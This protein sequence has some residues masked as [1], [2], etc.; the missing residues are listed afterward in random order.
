MISTELLITLGGNAF[1]TV[2]MVA[3][4]LFVYLHNKDREINFLFFY[5][6]MAIAIF[7]SGFVFAGF[8][9]DPE[10][11]YR[12]WFT[13]I[14][15]VFI[16]TSVV[17]V[18]IRASDQQVRFRWYLHLT[19][20]L[21]FII[22]GVALMFPLLFL[23]EVAPKMYFLTYLEG[24]PW[25]SVMLAY[26]LGMPI[27]P[28]ILLIRYYFISSGSQRRLAEYF[29]LMFAV[30]YGVGPLDFPL[31]FNWQIDPVY[32]MFL[33][34]YLVPVAYGI[35]TDQ[36]LD[37]RLVIKRAFIYALGVAV[38]AGF[39]LSISLL[40]EL[41]I[42]RLPWISYW[43]VPFLAAIVAVVIGRSVWQQLRETDRLKYEFVT[44]ATHKLRTP[45]TR[46]RWIS[47]EVMQRSN[48]PAIQEGVTRISSAADQLIELTNIMLEAAK[49]EDTTLWYRKDPVDLVA[50][51]KGVVD[52]FADTIREKG[53][54][55]DI[56][57]EVPQVIVTGDSKRI[58]SVTEIF[59]EN[60]LLYTPKGG[61]IS[62]N[63]G[64]KG[65]RGFVSVKDTGIG[66]AFQ[67]QEHIFTGFF[68]SDSAKLA[69]TEGFGLGL[70]MAKSII[71]RQGGTI[72]LDSDGA[73]KGSEFWFMLPLNVAR[74][75]A[76][77]DS[78]SKSL[79]S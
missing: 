69:H 48:D 79:I 31:V 77:V 39:L 17:H 44:V 75:E 13:N 23:P 51:T 50:L 41:I 58:I 78:A 21:G 70:S 24:G 27:F 56:H 40:N 29:I 45:L 3:M 5:M 12:V 32:G 53:L 8:I 38:T 11:A 59:V 6:C 60:A 37:I 7:G 67:D 20:I 26:F 25:Y 57:T 47:A 63:I 10:I 16:T 1:F 9:A 42:V 54:T 19:Y 49:T 33:G 55:I 66:I 73:G 71:E 72:G 2:L 15:D 64:L 22:L 34:M 43:T 52:H 18:M 36:L 65:R 28:F 30:G 14:L 74:V 62:V 4:G 76:K 35:V 46:I 68:R 61:T